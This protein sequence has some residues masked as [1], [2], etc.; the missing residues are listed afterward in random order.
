MIREKQE[1]K[2]A[3]NNSMGSIFGFND[4]SSF[5]EEPIYTFKQ[6]EKDNRKDRPLNESELVSDEK[7]HLKI[8]AKIG[9]IKGLLLDILT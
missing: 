6:E 3:I 1:N 5:Q 7:D 2:K 8:L 4:K 9:E